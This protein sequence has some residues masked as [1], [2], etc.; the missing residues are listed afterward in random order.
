MLTA[1]RQM[2]AATD[3]GSASSRMTASSP[4][5]RLHGTDNEVVIHTDRYSKRPLVMTGTRARGRR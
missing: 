2:K 4:L 1:A 3:R 5:A